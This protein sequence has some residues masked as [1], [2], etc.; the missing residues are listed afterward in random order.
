MQSKELL[1][2]KSIS[3]QCRCN[4]RRSRRPTVK[5]DVVVVTNYVVYV[6]NVGLCRFFAF[7]C[8]HQRSCH[9]QP[10]WIFK[11][12]KQQQ[13]HPTFH[14]KL[15][16]CVRR[17]S[18]FVEYKKGT[19]VRILCSILSSLHFHFDFYLSSDPDP[20]ISLKRNRYRY[21]HKYNLK[22]C[23]FSSYIDQRNLEVNC[24]IFIVKKDYSS[25]CIILCYVRGTFLVVITTT[26]FCAHVA[27]GRF[28]SIESIES[29]KSIE[30]KEYSACT[31]DGTRS[32]REDD[33]YYS[34]YS[35]V[36]HS[37]LLS[38]RTLIILFCFSMSVHKRGDPPS[39]AGVDLFWIRLQ[40]QPKSHLI[41]QQ[42]GGYR[43]KHQ[44][45]TIEVQTPDVQFG[46]IN[47][48]A[49]GLPTHCLQRRKLDL[50]YYYL[51]LLRLLKLL[52]EAST[53]VY[54]YLGNFTLNFA[55][56]NCD[57]KSPLSTCIHNACS[58][59]PTQ[60]SKIFAWPFCLHFLSV[61]TVIN[62]SISLR[63]CLRRSSR[64]GCL[65]NIEIHTMLKFQ[66]YDDDDISLTTKVALTEIKMKV[67][68]TVLIGEEFQFE[69]CL[70][71][72]TL[73]PHVFCSYAP[74]SILLIKILNDQLKIIT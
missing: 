65:N 40:S 61:N 30:Y 44:G 21:N 58:D 5:E 70:F 37:H 16:R 52:I 72:V 34:C 33:S 71:D 19:S 22:L 48:D 74:I 53:Y 11:Q 31:E 54:K 9:D 57:R 45:R 32:R 1:R 68:T 64:E 69:Q 15:T 51:R 29:I 42:K 47:H 67:R 25:I 20:D 49:E 24:L 41:R 66:F 63:A 46:L 73:S 8:R 43:Q 12:P 23:L 4:I 3:Q 2:K 55:S 38:I 14:G 59:K 7:S 18:N 35:W 13:S 56:D 60:A 50:H 6:D 36:V 10:S 62:S 26:V 28:S 39:T 17:Y 27:L